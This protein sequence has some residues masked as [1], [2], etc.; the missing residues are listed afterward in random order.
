MLYLIFIT[1]KFDLESNVCCE[2][3]S[4]ICKEYTKFLNAIKDMKKILLLL[5]CLPMLFASC[6]DDDIMELPDDTTSGL[7]N[8]K[9]YN[10]KKDYLGLISKDYILLACESSSSDDD[11]KELVS[12][13]DYLDPAYKYQIITFENYKYKYIPLRF[14]MPKTEKEIEAIITDLEGDALVSFA[15]YTFQSDNCTNLIGESVGSL[16]VNTF[17][18]LFYVKVLDQEDLTSLNAMADEMEVEVIGQNEY[19]SEW[20]VLRTTKESQGDALKMA[21]YFH[22]SKLFECAEPEIIQL[23]IEF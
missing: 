14:D 1:N 12:T 21:N 18:D 23:P 10:D 9:Y 3:A 22:E 16:C 20:F 6:S 15:H 8:F 5:L 4:N 19:M 7:L 11:I 17:S 13:K 2:T